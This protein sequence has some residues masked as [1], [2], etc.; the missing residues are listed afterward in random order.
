[1]SEQLLWLAGDF[2][3]DERLVPWEDLISSD[4]LLTELGHRLRR[5]GWPLR[6]FAEIRQ[7]LLR[8]HERWKKQQCKSASF[9]EWAAKYPH[10][11]IDKS[12]D[13]DDIFMPSTK[14]KSTSSS[15]GKSTSSLNGKSTSSS[16]G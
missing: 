7:E 3:V 5:C 1:M 11:W 12:D 16:K 14:V 13:E 9:L 10:I 4:T 8:L 2:K 15:K 6:N